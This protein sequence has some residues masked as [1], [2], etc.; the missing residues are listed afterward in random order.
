MGAISAL[1]PK[2]AHLLVSECTLEKRVRKGIES[3]VTELTL[4]HAALRKVAKV[5]PDQLDKGV[6]IW[7]ENVKELS[8]QM[9]DIVD[10]FMVHVEDGG[11]PTNPKNRVKKLLK[12]T[13]KLFKKGKDLHSISGALEE[14]LGQ[15]KQLAEQR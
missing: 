6:K 5:P 1:L 2:L 4:M 7:A 10:T 15:A 12:K 14:V 9:E 8:Y 11:E 3:L 13:V